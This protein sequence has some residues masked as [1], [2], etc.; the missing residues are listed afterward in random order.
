MFH[1]PGVQVVALV[2]VAGPVPPPISVV[3]P[4]E[5]AVHTSCGQIKCTCASMPP[6]VTI[7]PSPAIASRPRADDHSR[8]NAAHDVGIAGLADRY[9]TAAADADVGLDDS[10]MVHDHRVRD[11]HIESALF[12]R[13]RGGLAHAVP[14]HL[15]AAELGFVTRRREVAFDFDEKVGIRQPN[16]IAHGGAVKAG[17]LPARNLQSHPG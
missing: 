9:D 14:Q 17:V 7:L 6:A 15:A 1:G 11:H 16:A 4:A 12:G 5:R 13:C 2:P 10:P 8:S 3:R